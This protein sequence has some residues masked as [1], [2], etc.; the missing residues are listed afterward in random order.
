[1]NGDRRS[2][3]VFLDAQ[4]ASCIRPGTGPA[5]GVSPSHT[6]SESALGEE[7]TNKFQIFSVADFL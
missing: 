4:N 1:M 3:D 5:A 7:V 2:S 6:K